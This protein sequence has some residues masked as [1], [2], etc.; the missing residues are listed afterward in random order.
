MVA[1]TPATHTAGIQP[2]RRSAGLTNSND[3]SLNLSAMGLDSMAS[4]HEIHDVD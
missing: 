3:G 1:S 4:P 2:A